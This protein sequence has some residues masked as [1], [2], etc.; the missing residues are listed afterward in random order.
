MMKTNP[1]ADFFPSNNLVSR[2][3]SWNEALSKVFWVALSFALVALCQNRGEKG[4]EME[5]QRLLSFSPLHP[6]F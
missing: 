5:N 1:H 3:F 4:Q 2:T 6:Y